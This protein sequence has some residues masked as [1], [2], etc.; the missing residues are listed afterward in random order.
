MA[1]SLFLKINPQ[2]ETMDVFALDRETLDVHIQDIEDAVK[3]LDAMEP[4][5]E[6]SES[7]EKWA[8]LHETLE[9][10]LDEA[11]DAREETV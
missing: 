4:G 9:D 8:Q 10:L 11:L 7:Y 2:W 5:D 3:K 1:K 6:L